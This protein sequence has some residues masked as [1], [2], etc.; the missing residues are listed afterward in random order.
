MN[1]K[2]FLSPNPTNDQADRSTPVHCPHWNSVARLCLLA[3]DGLYLPVPR[4]IADFCEGGGQV[5]CP[6]FR[7]R[8][9]R[10]TRVT[11]RRR[12]VRLSERHL[13]RF[14]EISSL[15]QS[16]DVPGAEAWTLDLSDHGLCVAATCKL[17]PDTAICFQLEGNGSPGREGLGRVVW[18]QPLANTSLFEL[19]VA[20]LDQIEIG[21]AHV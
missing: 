9:D 17:R 15:G 19:G 4:H 1:R 20:L 2:N 8:A 16:A 5:F 11:N 14:S 13:F 10:A 6:H 3:E 21:R 12:S 18:C 7:A